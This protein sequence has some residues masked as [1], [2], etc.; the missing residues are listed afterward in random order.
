MNYK[1]KFPKSVAAQGSNAEIRSGSSAYLR[2]DLFF[3]KLC[4]FFSCAA[5]LVGAAWAQLTPTV[6]LTAQPASIVR[7]ESTTLSW[8]STDAASATI[9][10][11]IGSVAL[12]GSRV[13]SPAATTTYTITVTLPGDGSVTAS[14]SATVTVIEPD[15]DSPPPACLT[16]SAQPWQLSFALPQ[17]GETASQTVVLHAA[18]GEAEFRIQSSQSWITATPQ[19]GSLAADQRTPIAVAVD[20]AGLPEGTRSGRLHIFSAGCLATRVEVVLEVLP[21]QGPTVSFSGG[22]VNAAVMSAFG[23]PGPFGPEL[24]PL[25]PGSIVAVLGS[26]FT[27]GETLVSG[28]FPLPA[29]LSGVRVKFNSAA[30]PQDDLEAPL[31]AAESNLILAQLPAALAMDAVGSDEAATATVVVETAEG[32]S[33]PRSFLVAPHG[34]GIFTMSGT[35]TGQGAVVLA[36]TTVLAAPRGY[37]EGVFAAQAGGLADIYTTSR[38]ARA[39][40]IVEIYATGLG[41]VDPPIADGAN[42]CEPDSVCPEDFSNVVLRRTVEQPQVWIGGVEAKREDVLFSG[43]AP[44]LAGMNM[45]VVKVPQ[46]IEP[47]NQAQIVI[48]VGGQES[49]PGVTIA[50]E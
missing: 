29:N 40:E 4:R 6:T 39:G 15:D 14:A 23:A 41:A 37:N 8:T 21:S 43:L 26:N 22:V 5:L 44:T 30:G 20:P 1:R 2:T 35:G 18:D 46:G 16:V 50:L 38:P 33:Y 34:P 19:S 36:G 32:S 28:T 24:L 47:S 42:S 45:V 11:G 31:F 49:Q 12:N 10:Q 48:A 3:F 17:D 27:A 7:G 9:D 25:A 13:V